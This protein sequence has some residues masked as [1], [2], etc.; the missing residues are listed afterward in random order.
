MFEKS[1]SHTSWTV[2]STWSLMFVERSWWN[3]QLDIQIVLTPLHG[4][5]PYSLLTQIL[6]Q[7]KHKIESAVGPL[8]MRLNQVPK[9]LFI[10]RKNWAPS[11]FCVS[12][13]VSSKF[14]LS[15]LTLQPSHLQICLANCS[16]CLYTAARDGSQHPPTEGRDGFEK[17]RYERGGCK[18]ACE[19]QRCSGHGHKQWEDDCEQEQQGGRPG[20]AANRAPGKDALGAHHAA[21]F[22][23]PSNPR[24]LSWLHTTWWRQSISCLITSP[25]KLQCRS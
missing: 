10:L 19:L 21:Q 18:W 3:F 23:G 24:E 14:L 11:A 25:I 9:M 5:I 22:I 7:A 15:S 6:S 20:K 1:T 2:A 17:V 8:N 16:S 4:S 13:K 12:F